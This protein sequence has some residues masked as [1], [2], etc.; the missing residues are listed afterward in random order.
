MLLATWVA[1]IYGDQG[2]LLR[3][4]RKVCVYN[5][6]IFVSDTANHRVVVFDYTGHYLRKFG[7]TGGERARLQ[8]PYGGV[9]VGNRIFVAEAGLRKAVIFDREGKFIG[10]FGEKAL[11]KSVDVAFYKR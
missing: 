5:D 4:P 8:Y 11:A 2:V 10:Y 1:T 7:D 3:Q 6:E 9:V